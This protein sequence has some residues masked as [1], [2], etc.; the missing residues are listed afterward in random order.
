[1]RKKRQ[2]ER[3]NVNYKHEKRG[4]RQSYHTEFTRIENASAIDDISSALSIEK[5]KPFFFE[6]K[7]KAAAAATS[8]CFSLTFVNKRRSM[9]K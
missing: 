1:M 6:E 8:E 4:I 2:N 3:K 9:D 7:E 5:R